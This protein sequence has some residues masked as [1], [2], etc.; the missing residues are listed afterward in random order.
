[1]WVTGGFVA[2]PNF[3]MGHALAYDGSGNTPGD[4]QDVFPPTP[5][6]ANSNISGID[7]L[8]VT[9]V[10]TVYPNPSI[11]RISGAST[12][13]GMLRIYD[14]RGTLVREMNK[15]SEVVTLDLDGVVSGNYYITLGD[16]SVK[17]RKD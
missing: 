2:T 8:D 9:P 15:V 1:Q 13:R 6:A 7:Y 5:D 3:L 14:V 11:D 4:W 17:F 16:L 12:A 10:I